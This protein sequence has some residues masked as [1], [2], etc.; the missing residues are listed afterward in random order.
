VTA[1]H[2]SA[3]RS[4][5]AADPGESER[6]G[7][8]ERRRVQA[9]PATSPR[10]CGALRLLLNG[11]MAATVRVELGGT[12]R[13]GGDTWSSMVRVLGE[14]GVARGGGLYR[15]GGAPRNAGPGRGAV[16]ARGAA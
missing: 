5:T 9:A 16:R 1:T 7:W 13:V 6:G 4:F 8:R 2:G 15:Q 10:P 12:A 11:G 14:N 3:R